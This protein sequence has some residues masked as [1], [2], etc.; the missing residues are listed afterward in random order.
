MMGLLVSVGF[1]VDM[2]RMY[3]Y[4]TELQSTADAAALAGV[5]SLA[6][7]QGAASAN[8][9]IDYN[10]RNKVGDSTNTLVAGDIYP[11][12]WSLGGV[13]SDRTWTDLD[14]NAVK[15]TTRY[16][17]SFTFGRLAGLTT[18][19]LTATAIAVH[20]SVG[21]DKCVRPWA[22]PYFL[23]LKALYPTSTPDPTTYKL[24][25]ADVD[26]LAA[27]TIADNVALK[28]GDAG[29]TVLSG[30]F[31]GVEMPPQEYANGTAGNPWSGGN[32]YQ[33]AISSSCDAL[34]T[35]MRARG[36]NPFVGVGD[37]L[38]PENGN[39]KTPTKKAVQDLCGIPNSVTTCPN[40]VRV[41]IALWD[42]SGNAPHF[43][44]GCGGKCFHVNYMGVFY[45]TG[46]DDASDSVTGYFQSMSDP[47]GGFI[48]S[49]GPV[50]KNALVR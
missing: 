11:G 13:W 42:Q 25:D 45:V 7:N 29:S 16:P 34:E 10:R 31:Y 22:V 32:N 48:A 2:S 30:N 27:M 38:A 19:N 44:S 6:N 14:A 43:S 50:G 20:G 8:D 49:P 40:P 28:V 33:D 23:L 37:W 17:G 41:I 26:R 12:N 36:G 1:A 18:K 35:A 4:R 46:Y 3:L 9:A 24:S 47:G 39:M 5:L 15:V 21:K